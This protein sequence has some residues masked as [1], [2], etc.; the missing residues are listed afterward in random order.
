M[1]RPT[2]ALRNALLKK[3][4][5]S[6]YREYLNGVLWAEIRDVVLD[7]DGS[8]CVLCGALARVIHHIDYQESTLLGDSLEA[9]VS[10]CHACHDR[11]ELTRAGKKRTLVQA[12]LTYRALFYEIDKKRNPYRY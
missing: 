4:G 5:Y 7:R 3:L 8:A 1:A 11:I 6:S 9:L 10:L 12:Q 2:Y